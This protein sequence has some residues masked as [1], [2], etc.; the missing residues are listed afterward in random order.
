[1]FGRRVVGIGVVIG[2]IE[3]G[4]GLEVAC[5]L[6]VVEVV[7]VRGGRISCRSWCGKLRLRI[8]RL[9]VNPNPYRQ[10]FPGRHADCPELS[11]GFRR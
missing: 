9:K 3:V 10:I 4:V 7:V 8:G 5:W 11:D 6:V 1:L 2:E